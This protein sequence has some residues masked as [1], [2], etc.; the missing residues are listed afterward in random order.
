MA[1]IAYRDNE[2]C[3]GSVTFST[4]AGLTITG[5]AS[6][7]S[8]GGIHV[9]NENLTLDGVVVSGNRTTGGSGGGGIA[10]DNAGSLTVRSSTIANNVV[11]T[12][13]ISARGGG[14]FKPAEGVEICCA[15]LLS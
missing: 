6:S 1:R 14:I 4:T 12:I 3:G 5:G 8:G 10:I 15:C 9:T 11:E 2:I 7:A 13:S